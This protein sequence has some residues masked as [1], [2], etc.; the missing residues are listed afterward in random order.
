MN[1]SHFLSLKDIFKLLVISDDTLPK[2]NILHYN[3]GPV[4]MKILLCYQQ[5]AKFAIAT[6]VNIHN[7]IHPII[8]YFKFTYK[9]QNKYTDFSYSYIHCKYAIYFIDQNESIKMYANY[10]W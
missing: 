10:S 8:S 1:T 3:T 2:I 9:N 4:V 7:L 6:K 5:Y